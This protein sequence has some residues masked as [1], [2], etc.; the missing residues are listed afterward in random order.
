MTILMALQSPTLN[1][2][3][4]LITN[5]TAFDV[6]FLSKTAVGEGWAERASVAVVAP[7]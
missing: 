5:S 1:P 3:L 6:I 2:F 7:S 4:K